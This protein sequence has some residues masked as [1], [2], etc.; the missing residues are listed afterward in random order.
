MPLLDDVADAGRAYHRAV[1]ELEAARAVLY[2]RVR[3]TVR[4]GVPASKVARAAGLSRERVRQIVAKRPDES[5][6]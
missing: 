1:S 4:E 5:E 3:A 2:E 6:R